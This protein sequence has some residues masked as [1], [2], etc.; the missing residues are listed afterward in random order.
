MPFTA[1]AALLGVATA[2]V[3]GGEVSAGRLWGGALVVVA[4]TLGRA[5]LERWRR[6][7]RAGPDL[8]LSDEGILDATGMGAPRFIPWSDI[9]SVSV[10]R[11]GT[12][13]L[14]RDGHSVRR[15]W[16]DRATGAV[17]GQ[18][19]N[20]VSIRTDG[21]GEESR[22]VGGLIQSYHERLLLDEVRAAK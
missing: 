3:A 2:M 4:V 7:R 14:L 16:L 17:F 10:D 1:G 21:F 5:A 18:P 20:R 6:S 15:G 11:R 12:T 13:A 19:A 22:E 8:V 9:R